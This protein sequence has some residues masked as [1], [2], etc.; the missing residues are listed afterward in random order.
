MAIPTTDNNASRAAERIR[1]LAKAIRSDCVKYIAM[2]DTGSVNAHDVVAAFGVNLLTPAI[3]EWIVLKAAAGVEA[4]LR[5]MFPGVWASDAAVTTELNSTQTTMEAT[6]AYI[7]T[8]TPKDAA[9]WVETLKVDAANKFEQRLITSAPAIA[10]L[11]AQIVLLRD[12][13]S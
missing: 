1:Q 9:G 4:A 2:C 10:G 7:V 5:A 6:M 11:R 8:N 13:F 12:A 3:A